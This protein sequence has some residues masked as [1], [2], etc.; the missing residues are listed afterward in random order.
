M[1]EIE[2]SQAKSAWNLCWLRSRNYWELSTR[3]RRSLE[4]IDFKNHGKQEDT[5]QLDTQHQRSSVSAVTGQ[6]HFE[7]E[8]ASFTESSSSD[9]VVEEQ[10]YS[11]MDQRIEDSIDDYVFSDQIEEEDEGTV[12]LNSGRQ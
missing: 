2:N 3:A 5:H 4:G 9:F 11:S 12:R 10:Q 6:H 7:Q 1:E 8:N